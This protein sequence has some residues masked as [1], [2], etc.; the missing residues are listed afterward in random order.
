ME[1]L[2]KYIQLITKPHTHNICQEKK[3]IYAHIAKQAS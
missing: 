1:R 2:E 3:A